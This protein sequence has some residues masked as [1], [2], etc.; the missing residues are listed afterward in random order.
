MKELQNNLILLTKALS[1]SGYEWQLDIVN[2][3]QKIVGY[4]GIR[5]GG[6][7][8]YKIGNGKK[9]IFISAHMDEVGFFVTKVENN[10][11]RVVPIGDIS[12]EDAIDSKIIVQTKTNRLI[13]KSI[14]PADSFSSLKI[15]GLDTVA[16]GDVGTF[17]KR[18]K[19]KN[20]IV[21]ATGLDNKVGCSTLL[22]LI[23]SLNYDVKDK[24]VYISFSCQ[25]EVGTNG[26]MAAVKEIDPSVCIEIDSAYAKGPEF[27]D[28]NKK[29][30]LIPEIGKGPAIQ[31]MGDGF[32][33]SGRDR[34]LVESICQ[35]NNIPY[36]YE[37]PDG[38]NGGTNAGSLIN[39]GYRT[40][41]IN[42][43]VSNQHSAMSTSSLTDISLTSKLVDELVNVI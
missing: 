5:I 43:P 15:Y 34:I 9:K 41:Q 24:T 31:F 39:A 23:K 12:I 21:E 13:S 25:E 4:K 6:N 8:V 36:Q 27:F 17:E 37:I 42:I 30:W 11:A 33:I 38:E 20:D 16:V 32:I 14:K 3:I 2:V 29:N 22:K 18:I 26:V 19:F 28:T 40:I 35:K 10:Y 1:I 7:L